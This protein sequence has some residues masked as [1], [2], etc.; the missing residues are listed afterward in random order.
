MIVKDKEVNMLKIILILVFMMM[1]ISAS[2]DTWRPG[3]ATVYHDKFEGRRTAS[4]ERFT[5]RG[6]TAAS[7]GIARGSWIE[8]RYG[9]NGRSIVKVNDTGKLYLDR[10]GRPQFDLTKKVARELGLYNPKYGRNIR[11]RYYYKRSK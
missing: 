8:L 7:R 5:H 9:K 3:V 2:A 10:P 11:W 1:C 4:G 6:H